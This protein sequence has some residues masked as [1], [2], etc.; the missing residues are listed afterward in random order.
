MLPHLLTKP[1][2]WYVAGPLIGLLPGLVLLLGNKL[3]GF[4][5]NLRHT[6]A[7]LLRRDIAFFRYDWRREGGWNL[8]LALGIIVGGLLAG[9][10]WRNPKPVA[11]SAATRADLAAL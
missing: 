4:S 8:A 1:W 11:I 3:F 7:A 10:V 5:S 9:V 2:P 6:C